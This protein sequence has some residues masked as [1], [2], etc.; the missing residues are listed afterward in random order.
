MYCKLSKS[1]AGIRIGVWGHGVQVH[2]RGWGWLIQRSVGTRHKCA[3]TPFSATDA[4][5]TTH[6]QE[7]CH[8]GYRA[9]NDVGPVAEDYIFGLLSRGLR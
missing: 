9:G 2:R 3:G 7:A 4:A 6:D 5:A 8:K 1:F